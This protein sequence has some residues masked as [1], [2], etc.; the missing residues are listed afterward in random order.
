MDRSCVVSYRFSV[1]VI[2]SSSTS[3]YCVSIYLT[4]GLMDE[5]HVNGLS[6]AD[7]KQE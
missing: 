2:I 6:G 1:E 5:E 3:A 7:I 4:F